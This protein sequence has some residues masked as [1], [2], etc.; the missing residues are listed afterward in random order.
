MAREEKLAWLPTDPCAGQTSEVFVKC[1]P[2]ERVLSG[3]NTLGNA[4]VQTSEVFF[5]EVDNHH[6]LS[7]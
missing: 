3:V 2:D 4:I 7:R 5:G 6:K 1:G